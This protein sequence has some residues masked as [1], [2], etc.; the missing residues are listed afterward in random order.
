MKSDKTKPS[1]KAEL[2]SRAE[3]QLKKKEKNRPA[4]DQDRNAQEETQRLVHE[5]RVHEI[6]LEMQND[7]L[8]ASRTIIEESRSKYEDLYDFPPIGY[9]T[10]D[11]KGLIGAANLTGASLLGKERRLLIESPFSNLVAEK[12]LRDFF[13]HLEAVFAAETKQ[14]CEL[15]L[16]T[17]VPVALVSIRTEEG[18]GNGG[19]CRSAVIDI[20]KRKQAEEQLRESEEHFRLTFDKSPLGAAM[21]GIDQRITRANNELCRML[22]YPEEEIVG[23]PLRDVTHPDDIEAELDNMRAMLDGR[24]D[25]FTMEKRYIRKDGGI[26]WGRLK[27]GVIRDADGQPKHAVRMIEDI[28]ERKQAERRQRLAAEILRILN[29]PSTLDDSI[30]LILAAIK[31]ETGFDAVG[32]RLR[33]G[34]DFPYYMTNGFSEDFIESERYLCERDEGG[35]I[36]R[37]DQKNPVLACMCGTILRGQAKTTLPFFTEGGSVWSNSTTELLKSTTEQDRQARTRNRCNTEGY[38][39]VALSPISSDGKI[40]GLLQLND[41]RRNQFT[42]EMIKFIEGLGASI[43]IAMVRKQTERLL[44]ERTVQMENANKQLES[45]SYSISHDLRAPLR[46][47]DGYSRMILKRKADQFDEET[48]RQFS[49]IR[50]NAQKMN[51]L[52]DD[53]LAFSRLDRQEMAVSRIDMEALVKEVWEGLRTITSDRHVSL[54]IESLTPGTG[55]RALIKQVLTNLLSNAIKY[56]GTRDAALVEVGGHADENE[57]VYYVKDNGVGFNMEY[58]HKLF[59]VFQRLHRAEEFEGTGVGLAIVQRIVQ[60]HGG[61]VWAEGEVDKGATFYFTLPARKE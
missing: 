38:E 30:T 37:D 10:F 44:E 4:D 29:D 19:Q 2:R 33:S 16:K 52:I 53:V 49:L 25:S 57:A 7:E 39:S 45:F 34:D 61:R 1:G 50:D 47:I 11:R 26:V 31:Q 40:I 24:S 54:R 42:P 3:E 21:V 27:A 5:L 58:Y 35:K 48:T 9:F 8:R 43:G 18:Q 15:W 41:R 22:G 6:E 36:I 17:D 20:T 32:I 55:D 59:G 56:T 13:S 14:T 23:R 28:T 12:S 51:Q 60:R 46:A